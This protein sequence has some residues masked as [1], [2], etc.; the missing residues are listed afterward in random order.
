MDCPDTASSVMVVLFRHRLAS[1]GS[2]LAGAQGTGRGGGARCV[3]PR[4]SSASRAH[5]R[6]GLLDFAPLAPRGWFATDIPRRFLPFPAR[7]GRMRPGRRCVPPASSS[8]PAS[9]SARP[10]IHRLA[11]WRAAHSG[12]ATPAPA[13]VRGFAARPGLAIRRICPLR[14]LPSATAT[15]PVPPSPAYCG[16]CAGPR[17]PA[18]CLFHPA[19]KRCGESRRVTDAAIEEGVPGKVAAGGASPQG[20]RADERARGQSR[21]AG[22][23]LMRRRAVPRHGTARRAEPRTAP[24]GSPAGGGLGARNSG[25]RELP[26][27]PEGVRRDAA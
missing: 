10:S 25:G 2:Q 4:V 26:R 17:F 6:H 11:G 23:R 12:G 5:P 7:T 22:R 1:S 8:C 27:S 16:R 13:C 21:A 18:F 24:D 20:G 9:G 3:H 15:P 19:A 14:P